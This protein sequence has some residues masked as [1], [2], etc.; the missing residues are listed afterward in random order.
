MGASDHQHCWLVVCAS[1]LYGQYGQWARGLRFQACPKNP[2]YNIYIVFGSIKRWKLVRYLLDDVYQDG[3][4]Q[5]LYGS[6]LRMHGFC[7]FSF[8]VAQQWACGLKI[9][10]C[11]A[12]E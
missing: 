3:A 8:A 7:G 4:L 6:W 12:H 9:R 2:S 1:H 10:S 5:R 11:Y